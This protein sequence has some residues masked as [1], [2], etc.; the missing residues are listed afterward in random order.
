MSLNQLLDSKISEER[1][2]SRFSKWF[3]V[4]AGGEVKVMEVISLVVAL[5]FSLIQALAESII[6]Y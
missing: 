6:K 4:G 5:L 3:N 2:S 1:E